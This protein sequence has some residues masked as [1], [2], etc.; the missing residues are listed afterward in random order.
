MNGAE[1]FTCAVLG[2][3]VLAL[4]VQVGIAKGEQRREERIERQRG[5][6]VKVLLDWITQA[7]SQ[8]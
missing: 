3:G 4:A 1:L 7:W 6:E 5:A 2:G 8:R